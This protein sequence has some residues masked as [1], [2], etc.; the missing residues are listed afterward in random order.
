LYEDVCSLEEVL[1]REL[2]FQELKS[3]LIDSFEKTFNIELIE[4]GFSAEE[5]ELAERLK[6]EKYSKKEWNCYGANI[7]LCQKAAVAE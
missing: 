3:L 2:R 1:G 6:Q 4:Q 7:E 5:M